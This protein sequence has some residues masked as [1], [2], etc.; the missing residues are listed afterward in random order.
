MA[1]LRSVRI[2][3]LKRVAQNAAAVLRRERNVSKQKGV[4]APPPSAARPRPK[5]EDFL[6]KQKTGAEGGMA[7]C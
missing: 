7:G 5:R 3:Y 1:S 4:D 2:A 6:R